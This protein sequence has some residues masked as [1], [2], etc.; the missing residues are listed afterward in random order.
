MTTVPLAAPRR[1]EFG[2]PLS[3]AAVR[4]AAAPARLRPR[5][6][7]VILSFVF[8]VLL[9]VALAGWYLWARAA[10]QFESRVGFAVR[11]EGQPPPPDLLSG[12]L[13]PAGAASTA[14]DM[15]ILA[16]FV[17]SQEIVRRIDARLDLRGRFSGQPQDPVFALAEAG[18]IEDLQDFWQRMVVVDH[19][20]ATG[21]MELTVFAFSARDAADIAAAILA[22][23]TEV[24][25][26]MS[27]LA[28]QDSARFARAALEEAK[29]RAGAAR[30]ALAGFRAAHNVADPAADIAMHL[31]VVTS[32]QQQLADAL[33][34]R[35]LA[36]LG[37]GARTARI[38]PLD[39]RIEVIEARIE[40][41]RARPGIGAAG[42]GFAEILGEYERLVVE[43][44][45]A[46]QAY[47]AAL[48]AHDLAMS[49]AAQN[50]RYL[51]TFLPPTRAEAA[52][53]P[54]RPL[55]LLLTALTAFLIWSALMLAVHALRDRR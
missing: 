22:E 33:I 55:A 4:P 3:L 18:T 37:G 47:L 29:A 46:D 10:D 20:P 5:H 32:L 34:E 14:E 19:N 6:M 45:F 9:P 23:C 1:P 12:L 52:T 43:L 7:A 44:G 27:D 49:S 48:T 51:A 2:P 31:G 40:G 28:R 35:D 30:A 8:M 21:L 54:I 39:Q 25:N 16:Q 26:T 41:E 38:A 53:A 17:Q 36:R 50:S 42:G 15:N 11:A 24:I 13:A